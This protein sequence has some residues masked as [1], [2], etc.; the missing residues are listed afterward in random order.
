MEQNLIFEIICELMGEE[1][2]ARSLAKKLGTNHMTVV[3]KLKELVNENVLDFRSEGRNKV[4]FL[5][6]SVEARNYTLRAELYRL[7]EALKSYPE[8]RNIIE[9]VQKNA[10][11]KL[12]LLFGSY[13]RGTA[14]KNSDIDLFV[15]TRNWKLKR[16]LELLNSKLSVKIGDFDRSNLLIKEIEKDHVIV[17]GAE[18]YYEKI[19]R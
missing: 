14:G 8:L 15:E 16:E 18:L 17:K 2:H 9:A 12:A 10:E 19:T 6:K 1:L 3:R 4:Y 7:N 5:K 13:A 11:I